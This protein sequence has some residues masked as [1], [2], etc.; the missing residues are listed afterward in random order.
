MKKLHIRLFI[1]AMTAMVMP[2]VA[3]AQDMGLGL[4]SYST[5]I[6]AGKWITVTNTTNMMPS[7]GDYGSS[8]V[9]NIGFEFPYAASTY[10]QFSVNSDGNMKLGSSATGTGD[11]STPFSSGASNSNNPKING[12]GCDG[13][14]TSGLHYARSQTFGDTLL[15]VEFCLGTYNQSTRSQLYKWQVHLYKSG[16]IEIVYGEAPNNNPATSFQIGLCVN[17]GDGWIINSSHEASHFT[18][19]SG[20]SWSSGNWPEPGRYYA[21]QPPVISC[22]RPINLRAS[23]VEPSRFSFAWDDE[24]GSTQYVVTLLDGE[25]EV[26]TRIVTGTSCDFSG[27]DPNTVYTVHVSAIC[28]DGDT[29]YWN[30]ARVETPCNAILSL[31]YRYDFDDATASGGNGEISSCWMRHAEGTGV[32]YPYPDNAQRHNGSYSL[33]LTSNASGVKSWAS[34]P[35]FGAPL[36]SLVVSFWAMRTASTGGKLRVGAIGYSY[37]AQTYENIADVQVSANNVWEYFEVPLSAYTGSNRYLTFMADAAATNEVYIDEVHVGYPSSCALPTACNVTNISATT[38]TLN[39]NHPAANRF[40]VVMHPVGVERYDTLDATYV[41]PLTSLMPGTY[42]EGRIYTNCGI[43][44]SVSYLPFRFCT[45]CTSLTLPVLF[46]AEGVWEG[47]AAAPVYPCWNFVNTHGSYGWRMPGTGSNAYSGEKSFYCYGT[48]SGSF[49]G[50]LMT[51]AINFTGQEEMTVW[52]K[53]TTS[54]TGASYHGRFGVYATVSGNANSSSS[55]DFS[56]LAITGASVDATTNDVDF[57]GSTWQQ[58]RITLP[59]TLVGLHRLALTVDQVSYSFYLDDLYIYS[60]ST[61][62]MVDSV[63][64]PRAYILGD[65]ARVTWRDTNRTGNYIVA[66]WPETATSSRDSLYAYTNV[67]SVTLTQLQRGVKYYVSIVAQCGSTGSTASTPVSFLSDCGAVADADLPYQET[68]ETYGSAQGNYISHCWYKKYTTTSDTSMYSYPYPYNTAAIGGSAIGLY[69]YG[70]SSNS[71]QSYAV[72]PAFETPYNELMLE[73]DLKRYT[74]ASTS[75]RSILYV[76][77]MTDPADLSTFTL[78]RSFDISS[79]GASAVRHCMLSL[80]EMRGTGRIA[81]YAPNVSSNYVYLDNVVVRRLPECRWPVGVQVD[82][83]AGAMVRLSWTGDATARY[84]MQ[85]ATNAVFTTGLVSSS[86]TGTAGIITGLQER[87]P[88]YV[89]VRRVC[90]SDFSNWSDPVSFETLR[91]CGSSTVNVLDTL[92]T[93]TNTKADYCFYVRSTT[94]TEGFSS[95]IFTARELNAMGL[96][97]YNRIHTIGLQVGGTGGTIRGARIYMR[98]VDKTS[99][100]ATA[101]TVDRATMTLVYSGD[102]VAPANS[103]IEVPLSTPFVYTGTDNLVVTFARDTL[104]TAQVTFYYTDG[105]TERTI[106]GYRNAGSSVYTVPGTARVSS[107]VNIAFD[108]CVNIPTCARPQNLRTISK[109]N[110]EIGV[111]WDGTAGGYQVLLTP[112]S[113]NPATYTGGTLQRT[114]TNRITLTGLTTNTDYYYYVRSICGTDTSLWSV[115][116]KAR[117]ACDPYQVPYTEGFDTYMGGPSASISNCWVK[118]TNNPNTQYPYP[119]ST[120]TISGTRILNFQSVHTLT[121]SEYSYAALPMFDEPINTLSLSF[122]LR[123]GPTMDANNTTRLVVG[124]MGNPDDIATFEPYDTVDLRGQPALSLHGTD[125]YFDRYSG[126]GRYIAIYCEAP[127][128]YGAST[129][130]ACSTFVDDVNV[131]RIPT[132]DRPKDIVFSVVK[133]REAVVKWTGNASQYEV[134]YGPAGFARGQGM[135]ATTGADS[136]LLTMLDPATEYDIYVRGRCSTSDASSWSYVKSFTTRCA[137]V[138]LPVHI[139]PQSYAGSTVPLCWNRVRNNTQ[140]YPRISNSSSYANTG[141]YCIYYYLTTSNLWQTIVFPEIDVAAHPMGSIRVSYWAKAQYNDRVSLQVGVM[142]D[143]TDDATFTPLA[144]HAITNTKTLYRDTLTGYTGSGSY[145]AIKMRQTNSTSYA[146]LDDIDIEH[147]SACPTVYGLGTVG[148][149]STTADLTWTD[150][151]SSISW[152]VRY[153]EVGRDNWVNAPAG[154][155]PHTL[156]GLT[157]N[158]SYRFRVAPVCANGETAAWSEE[159]QYFTTAQVPAAM[160]YSY[161]FEDGGEW[162]N[163]GKVS[164]ST[165]AWA[166]GTAA[167][168]NAT[169]TGYLSLDGGQ[170][171]SWDMHTRTN[172]IAYRDID[173][174]IANNAYQIEFDASMGGAEGNDNDGLSV[175]LVDPSQPVVASGNPAITAWGRLDSLESVTLR[176]DTGWRHYYFPIDHASGVRRLVIYH[177]NQAL[178]AG[179]EGVDYPAAI[180]NLSVVQQPCARP[181]DLDVLNVTDRSALV[182]WTGEAGSRYIIMHRLKDAGESGNIYDTVTGTSGTITGLTASTEYEYQVRRLCRLA[183]GDTLMSDWSRMGEFATLC[184]VLR[185]RDTIR[186]SFEDVA[187]EM[188]NVD[189]EVPTCWTAYSNGRYVLPH[190]TDGRSYSYCVDGMQALTLTSNSSLSSHGSENGVAMPYTEEPTNKLSMSFWYCFESS[191][192]GTLSVGYL[193]GDNF[194]TDFVSLKDLTPTSSAVHIGNGRQTSRGLRD[195]VSFSSVPAGNYRIAFKWTNNS[196][197]RTVCVDDICVWYG[198]ICR[199]PTTVGAV[200]IGY[201][202]AAVEATGS[203]PMFTLLFGEA[204]GQ[205]TDTFYSATGR[206]EF[207]GLRA[208]H[209]YY[210]AVRQDCDSNNH[211]GWRSG[212]FTTLELPC[213]SPTMY[214][215]TGVTYNSATVA[216]RH[217]SSQTSWLV[218]VFAPGFDR[219]DTVSETANLTLGELYPGTRYGVAVLPLCEDGEEAYWSDTVRFTTQSC[220]QVNSIQTEYVG[221]R[222]AALSWPAVASATSYAVEYGYEGLYQGGGTTDISLANAAVLSGLEPGTTYDVYVRSRCNEATYGLWSQRYQFSTPDEADERAYYTVS[223]L[224]SGVGGSVSGGGVVAAGGTKE[225]TA[226]SSSGWRFVQWSDGDINSRRTITVTRDTILTA[227]FGRSGATNTYYTVKVRPNN[228]SWGRAVGSGEYI[229]GARTAVKA[230]AAEGYHFVGWSDSVGGAVRFLTVDTNIVLTALFAEGSVGIETVDDGAM[231]VAIYPNPATRGVTVEVMGTATVEVVDFS[232]RMMMRRQVEERAQLDISQLASGAYFVRVTGDS[233][234]AIRKLIVAN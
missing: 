36:Q 209:E 52:V 13:M 229:A 73:F 108:I 104:S 226:T 136:I 188:Y 201:H 71:A 92:G 144:T 122:A 28:A 143:P 233:G 126:T 137:A 142:T 57:A 69:F 127:P 50:Y 161:D 62:P 184:F 90:G 146:G 59:D 132:C 9:T 120:P 87:T 67:P 53:T 232:G 130:C 172:A 218:H 76:G 213:G 101:D 206:F 198:T 217:H 125:I 39:I 154:T 111:A 121:T 181:L 19:G 164:S 64:V 106:Y 155:I 51:P 123:C 105:S 96:D 168:G 205:Y 46:G 33:H 191:I 68:F 134:E 4:Y 63:R 174:G 61:C 97:A 158:T 21:F 55:A 94:N 88:Y 44:S 93:G 26:S 214:M 81:F 177:Y 117:T 103:W 128:F 150:T 14:H 5:G 190:V 119:N 208:M 131:K 171:H 78:V 148:A 145:I 32:R 179:G 166:R 176:R 98:E 230:I 157:P 22:K 199:T 175:M 42:Y 34:L 180:D 203:A 141:T 207:T 140:D 221:T 47:A 60:R 215:P 112:T 3:T 169:T 82:S 12:M 95:S 220:Q 37:D 192:S 56:K 178:A 58:L 200:D 54:N 210:Y 160:P 1:A 118:G 222:T 85:A 193:T 102:L 135:M 173:F 43:D 147:I 170:T 129:S 228:A 165:A 227:S 149:T 100:T 186:E 38:A 79:L 16:R 86:C 133:A 24:S 183:P 7:A 162:N 17:S 20:T 151:I 66:Y 114:T 204:P 211:G 225:I 216:W 23:N 99:F 113:V 2:Q 182:S 70:A 185:A 72:M 29:S 35:E 197:T 219:Y 153:A 45:G 202:E 138:T 195:S 189:G 75:N 109:T 116:G 8:S 6:D 48:T 83:L 15:V 139:D 41:L 27:L 74:S 110:N 49:H 89:R 115:E 167:T 223:V 196:S 231:P 212:H 40:V 30:W 77:Q 107:R 65:S 224:S 159:E 10:R 124:V 84:E 156:V 152:W 194:F 234:T 80:E 187:G 163:W 31:P 25:A 11:Y 18:N 91:D